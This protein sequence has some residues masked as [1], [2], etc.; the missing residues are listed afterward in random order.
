MPRYLT[1]TGVV[2]NVPE[3]KY[4]THAKG[5]EEAP[6]REASSESTSEQPKRR[7]RPPKSQS[8]STGSDAT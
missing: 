3:E 5:L 6:P 1:K 8:E 4:D 7:G 2:I